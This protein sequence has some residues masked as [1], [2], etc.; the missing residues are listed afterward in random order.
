MCG[1]VGYIG[2]AVAE[3][4]VLS[5][6]VRAL[7]RLEYR[8]Y[9]GAGI[10]FLHDGSLHTIKH[11]DP[12]GGGIKELQKKIEGLS[13]VRAIAHTRWATHGAPSVA[14]THPHCVGGIAVVHNGTI[15]NFFALRTQFEKSGVQFKSD[16][17]TEVIAHLVHT[18]VQAG[19]T[20][21]DAVCSAVSH[22]A[23]TYGLVV[24]S[25]NIHD[26]LVVARHGSPL[27]V[28]FVEHAGNRSLFVASDEMALTGLVQQVHYLAE[29]ELASLHTN[30]TLEVYG[31]D[32][33]VV[34]N[35]YRDLA[36][37]ESS[38]VLGDFAHHMLKEIHQQPYAL[39]ACLRGRIEIGSVRV[40]LGML[41]DDALRTALI[42]A[43]RLTLLAQGTSYYAA[44]YA[45]LLFEE[46]A[47]IPTRVLYGS[48]YTYSDTVT[49]PGECIV[50]FS[51]SGT[52]A[53][54]REA[55]KLA[56]E[57][58]V[59]CVGITN[60]V[61]SEIAELVQGGIYLHAGPEVAV[62]STKAFTSQIAASVLL[63]QE[64][65]SLRG[66]VQ[67]SDACMRS[68]RLLDIPGM[69]RSVIAQESKIQNLA[70]SL[71]SENTRLLIVGRGYAFPVAHEAALKL[72]EVAY[73]DAHAFHGSELKHGPLAL[74]EQGVPVIGLIP[75]DSLV[76]KSIL[77]LVQAKSRGARVVVVSHELPEALK[78]CEL[79]WVPQV[80]AELYGLVAGPA[81]QLLAYYAGLT[82]GRA[83]DQPRNLAKSVTVE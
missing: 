78:D 35:R 33:D 36:V 41:R 58:A 50:A 81:M 79:L 68:Q 62:A 18:Y 64:L 28:G 4:D 20:L 1:I 10:G 45:A 59:V 7:A 31:V 75:A 44:Q 15:D 51:Q 12:V 43:P 46:I 73:V 66:S 67:R 26:P 23:G 55:L 5:T 21:P 19:Q 60:R 65:G 29:G 24:M 37:T 8:G 74:V 70:A 40:Q 34:E 11:A 83:I 57:R 25:D 30:G 13:A 9:D 80:S 49:L 53:D 69:V 71:V 61:G 22:L 3:V 82:L 6:V 32:T 14:N 27:C 47:H 52:T 72:Q 42:R 2:S 76:D 77:G 39:T 63:A 56:R 17:D 38:V 54:T 48:E 16:C